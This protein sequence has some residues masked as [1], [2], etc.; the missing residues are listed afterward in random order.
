VLAT[1]VAVEAAPLEAQLLPSSVFQSDSSSQPWHTAGPG[2]PLAAHRAAPASQQEPLQ[3]L[4]AGAASTASWLDDDIDAA[5]AAAGAAGP[6]VSP[7]GHDFVTLSAEICSALQ[8]PQQQPQQQPQHRAEPGQPRQR[9]RRRRQSA[10]GS[11]GDGVSTAVVSLLVQ[12]FTD[13]ELVLEA[14]ALASRRLQQHSQRLE[15]LALPSW[16]Q[17][18]ARGATRHVICLE[19]RCCQR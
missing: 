1:A 2:A 16:Q 10:A 5:P 15:L 13:V 11:A 7:A 4:A 14:I 6:L 8:L 9:R 3:H 18:T 17:H 19:L 12:R